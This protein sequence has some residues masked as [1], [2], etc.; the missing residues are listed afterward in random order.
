MV[1]P[2]L[3]NITQELSLV[4]VQASHPALS[5]SRRS[6]SEHK[7]RLHYLALSL[8]LLVVRG[9]DHEVQHGGVGPGLGVGKE[10]MCGDSDGGPTLWQEEISHLTNSGS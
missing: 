9:G 1:S 7:C 2:T 8:T 4:H 6:S 3:E 10:V 5:C